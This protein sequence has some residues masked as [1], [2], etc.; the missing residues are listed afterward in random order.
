MVGESRK[1]PTAKRA[2]LSSPPT[3]FSSPLKNYAR[4]I[5]PSLRIVKAGAVSV[6]GIAA[7]A[8]HGRP[9]GPVGVSG[10]GPGV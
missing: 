2:T 4:N 6:T 7:V 10:T 9:D 3:R 5:S 1:H 8:V